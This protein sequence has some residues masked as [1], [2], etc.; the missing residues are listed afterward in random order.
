MWLSQLST[1]HLWRKIPLAGSFSTD[2]YCSFTV[3]YELK[4]KIISFPAGYCCHSRHYTWQCVTSIHGSTLVSL[5]MCYLQ[6]SVELRGIEPLWNGFAQRQMSIIYNVVC[7]DYR[8]LHYALYQILVTISP[9]GWAF[10]LMLRSIMG[11]LV[12]MW[13]AYTRRDIVSRSL[14]ILTLH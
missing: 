5:V 10:Y 6:Y 14:P 8:L 7:K 1:T 4:I 11:I 12:A 2:M 3:L 13:L 9:E